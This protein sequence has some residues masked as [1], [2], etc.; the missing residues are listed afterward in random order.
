[1]EDL[2]FFI[3][4]LGL[5]I[6]LWIIGVWFVHISQTKDDS[7]TYGWG[8]YKKFIREFEKCNW[9]NEGGEWNYSMWDREKRSR[10]HAG[11]IQFN[12]IGMIINNPVDYVRVVMYTRKFYRNKFGMQ[13][14]N[15]H[16]W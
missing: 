10:Y 7:S 11:I 15:I 13:K 5:S 16:T 1:M 9:D 4:L 2:M 14:K 8:N 12:G 3:F 6:V